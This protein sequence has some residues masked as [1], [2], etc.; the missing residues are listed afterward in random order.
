LEE[1]KKMSDTTLVEQEGTEP[2][3]YQNS[4][5]KDLAIDDDTTEPLDLDAVIGARKNTSTGHVEKVEQDHDWKKRYSDLKRYH[6][7]KQNEWKQNTEL[8]EAQFEAQQR[9]PAELP[10]TAEELESFRM[11]YPEIFSVMQSVS[12]LEAG[13]RVSELETQIEHLRENEQTA[14]ETVSEQELLIRHPDFIELK[15]TDSFKEWLSV[16]PENISDGLYKNKSDVD[17]AA[18]VVDLYKLDTG[19]SQGEPKQ[20]TVRNDASVAIT[21]TRT[22]SD[23]NVS[24]SKKVWTN[25]EISRLKPHE[26]EKF[27]KEIETANRE[28][29]IA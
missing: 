6:D 9:V 29:R 24:D 11:E 13:S 2:T 22:S 19:H 20:S 23:R 10:K 7:T 5:R 12:Q 16:Q 26:F 15:E 28:G 27:E 18:R 3:P 21:K 1:N 8:L 14:R 25:L 4:Y 17:W